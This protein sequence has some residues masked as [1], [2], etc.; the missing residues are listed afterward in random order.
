MPLIQRSISPGAGFLAEAARHMHEFAQARHLAPADLSSL[1]VILP[2]L[3]L[4]NDLAQALRASVSGPVLLPHM[5]TLSGM[6]EAWLP[7]FDAVADARRQLILHAQLRSRN[8]FDESLLWDVVAELT[9]LFDTLT[10]HAVKLPDDEQ[11]LLQQ[12]AQAFE[13]N[14]SAALAFEARL[15]NTLWLAEAQGKPSRLSARVLACQAWMRQLQHPLVVVAEERDAGLLQGTLEALAQD[16]PVLLLCP[17]RALAQGELAE[18]LTAAWP[19]AGSEAVSQALFER[20]ERLAGTQIEKARACLGMVSA[21]S[22]EGLAQAVADQVLEWAHAG[23]QNIAL[24]ALDRLAAR[25]ARALLERDG[26][27]VQDETGWKMSTTRAAAVVDAWLEVLAS[28]AYHRALIDLLRAPMLFADLSENQHAAACLAV[29][30]LVAETSVASGLERLLKE[31]G[32]LPSA[33]AILSRLKD[34]RAV[35]QL[36]K[37]ASIS[38][39]LQRLHES[40]EVLG[41]LRSFEGDNAGRAWL[42]WHE[43]RQAELAGETAAFSFTSW[44]HWFNRQMDS[45]LFRDESI[46]S[47]VIMTHLAATRL[48]CFDGV[49]LVGADAEHMVP[50]T[51]PVWL[52]HSGLRRSLGLPPLDSALAQQREDIAGLMLSAGQTLV[53]WQSRNRGEELMPAPE[54]SMLI[55]TL[56]AQGKNSGVR[57]HIARNVALSTDAGEAHVSAPSVPQARIPAQLS[58]SAMQTLLSC[59]YRYFARYVLRLDELDVLS[60]AMEKSDFG[61]QLHDM[62]KEFHQRFPV[63]QAEEPA[64]LLAALEAM[65]E[66]AFAEVVERNFQDHAWRLR[67]RSRLSAYIGWQCKREQ[68]GWKWLDGE[69]ERRRDLALSNGHTLQLRGRIDRMDVATRDGG[70]QVALLDYKTRGMAALRKQAQDP[71]DIQLAFYAL[72]N[73][74]DV[75]EA[76]YVSLDDQSV[77]MARIADPL[78]RA[79]AL[80]ACIRACFDGMFG[81]QGLPAQGT[82]AACGYCEMR[83]ICRKEWQA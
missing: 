23:R 79:E 6:V 37:A 28:D 41:A 24:I 75:S 62:L 12:L 47:P 21:D 20:A 80:E 54:I 78:T 73:G 65:T 63:L 76:G 34:A 55:S 70:R 1:Q 39:W 83:G 45:S 14:D 77:D 74:M 4:A 53:A 10:E 57:R 50:G 22:L 29:E 71:D 72:L 51:Q 56:G 3:K 81:G 18:V 82:P 33:F 19:L 59:P 30:Q 40:L 58:A 66:T 46:D 17:D 35:M 61:N 5:A 64:A 67:W 16:L 48:R 27:L 31:A 15:V 42:E 60:E 69:V 26:V 36:G 8:W 32:K 44:R 49:I 52:A 25:R 9:G 68:E 11:E 7:Q 38:E 2:N 13:L 43:M